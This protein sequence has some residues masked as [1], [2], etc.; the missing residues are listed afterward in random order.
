MNS[1]EKAINT[2]LLDS[3]RSE[4]YQFKRDMKKRLD[5]YYDRQLPYLVE[6][7]RQNF[8]HCEPLENQLQFFNIVKPIVNETAIVYKGGTK[9]ILNMPNGEEVPHSVRKLWQFIL[10]SSQYDAVLKTVN[11]MVNL[12]KTVLVKPSFRKEQIRFDI[13]TPDKIDVFCDDEAPTEI[14]AV[15]Y[16]KSKIYASSNIPTTLIHYWDSERYLTLSRD[17]EI[18]PNPDNPAGIN[19]Y[20]V[21]PFVKFCNEVS[22]D[23]FF[24]RGGD[25]LIDAQDNINLKLVQLN[26]L[27][28]M[29]SFSVPVLTGYRGPEKITISPGKPVVIP[30]GTFSEQG[31]PDFRF[32]TPNPQIG[33]LLKILQYEVVRI[34]RSYGIA[35]DFALE[36]KPR[37]GFALIV[38]NMRLFENR[39]N[40]IPFYISSEQALFEVIKRVWNYHCD[41]LSPEH[42]FFGIKF[43]NDIKLDILINDVTTPRPISEELD[44]WEFML[45]NKLATP[46]DFLMW[47]YRISEEQAKNRW[48]TIK[49]FWKEKN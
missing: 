42:P 23:G 31:T 2:L 41:F 33:E 19:P 45:K 40:D 7:V 3:H 37:S 4:Q 25:D 27:V 13:I 6:L 1:F 47:K 12:C 11:R 49:S 21:L 26:Y 28:K 17:G 30:L 16:S 5:Y 14:S 36:Q 20:S 9:R 35:T 34:F 15:M 10:D 39:E 29:Q 46:I 24:V 48:E 18:V 44:E 32:E 38:E 22:S 8:A 43:P